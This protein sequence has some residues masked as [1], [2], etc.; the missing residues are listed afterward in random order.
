MFRRFLRDTKG[1]FAIMTV[2]ATVPIIGAIALAIDYGELTRQRQ[3]TLN[4][5]DAAGLAT[6]RHIQSGAADADAKRYAKDFFEANLNHIDPAKTTLN[7]ILPDESGGSTLKLTADLEYDPYF[8]PAF[9]TLIGKDTPELGFSASSEIRLKNTIEVALVLD[10]SGS[11]DFYSSGGKKR[12]DLLKA[13]SKQLVDTIAAQAAQ[14][15]QI[16]KPVQFAL[17]PFA[18][19]VNVGPTNATASWMDTGGL[20]PIHYEN[21]DH[22]IT[23]ATNKGFRKT[24]GV[25]YK[26]G[27]GWGAENG[28][29]VTR[30]TLFD[31]MKRTTCTGSGNNRVCVP[32][33]FVS[34][35]GCVEARPYPHNIQD[36]LPSTS[37]PASLVVPMFAPDET[38]NRWTTQK[39]SRGRDVVFTYSSP[40]S[41]WDDNTT[42]EA[43][44]RL[45][46]A[47]LA[48]Y[49]FT[50]PENFS[51]GDGPNYSCTTKPITPL[52]DVSTPDGVN[53]IKLAIDSMAP[54]GAT[55]VPEGLAWG[56]RVLSSQE[57][58][59]G[60]RPETEK[61]NDKIII[62]LTDGENTYYT[63]GGYDYPGN[64][65]TYSSYGYTGVNYSD[66]NT[67]RLFMNTSSAVSKTGYNGSNYTR[68]LNE[69]FARKTGGKNADGS[70]IYSGLCANAKEAKIIIM[71][72]A[73]DLN[74]SKP[75]EN[76]QIEAL[77]ECSSFSRFSRDANGK[78]KKLFWNTT[79]S[80][81]GDTF[82]SISDELSNLRIVG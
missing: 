2:I 34:W 75:V 59:T 15:K 18:A 51:V 82:K 20:S 63:P 65:S 47:S 1:N 68:A 12:M 78:P 9:T 17:V 28:Q 49:F 25:V 8:L 56:W 37:D 7:V 41:W 39:D 81:L 46:Q 57:P 74:K 61:G 71:T 76:A 19:S 36:T 5:L 70:D 24:N 10:N 22:T 35:D 3:A 62:V 38:G 60:G 79:G 69:H 73:L 33:A 58:F 45:R 13:A 14:L 66:T 29:I 55:N 4:A 32:K 53:S 31:E 64:K 52:T 30:F 77:T 21:F 72:V 40:N 11:M 42:S 67:T 26:N 43:S 16:E 80:D 48:K 6:A 54:L 50:A 27:T 44:H 23:V